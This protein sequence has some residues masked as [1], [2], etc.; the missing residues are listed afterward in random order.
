MRTR[1]AALSELV[2]TQASYV[3]PEKRVFG[4]NAVLIIYRAFVAL[5]SYFRLAD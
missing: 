1:P 2:P 3:S 4:L 5:N